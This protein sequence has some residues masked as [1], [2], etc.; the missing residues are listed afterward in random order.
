MAGQSSSRTYTRKHWVLVCR[1]PG[2]YR[3]LLGGGAQCLGC[4]S[5]EDLQTQVETSHTTW[6]WIW[7]L[8][9]GGVRL[10]TATKAVGSLLNGEI[11]G[12]FWSTIFRLK[13]RFERRQLLEDWLHAAQINREGNSNSYGALHSR[14]DR[15]TLARRQIGGTSMEV[16]GPAIVFPGFR[17]VGIPHCSF[18]LEKAPWGGDQLCK[19][20]PPP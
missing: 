4:S 18:S 11:T 5:W 19:V 12:F 10:N 1:H 17:E 6:G 8:Y 9:P 13:A 2:H 7:I 16:G 20:H 14:H 15:V 3:L